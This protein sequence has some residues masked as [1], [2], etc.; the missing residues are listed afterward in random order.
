MKILKSHLVPPKIKL[1]PLRIPSSWEMSYNSLIE[2]DPCLLKEDDENIWCNFTEDLLQVKHIKY[3]ILLDV[4]WYPEGDPTGSYGLELIK[5]HNWS[6]P[7]VS[8]DTRDKE[9]LV[10]KIECLLWQA[11]EGYYN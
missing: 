7:L 1:L 10:E 6:N 11:G 5:D 8:F 2:L 3:D 4:G 9:E